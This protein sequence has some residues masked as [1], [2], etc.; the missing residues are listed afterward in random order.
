MPRSL[1]SFACRPLC[2]NRLTSI[3]SEGGALK[4]AVADGS[5]PTKTDAGMAIEQQFGDWNGETLAPTSPEIITIA[6]RS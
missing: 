6:K 2:D 5:G 1:V 4:T 3:N